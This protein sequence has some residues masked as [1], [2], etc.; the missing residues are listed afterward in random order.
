MIKSAT[1]EEAIEGES[2]FPTLMPGIPRSS[3]RSMWKQINSEATV[4]SIFRM[5]PLRAVER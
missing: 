5:K 1:N 3:G 4:V 2:V